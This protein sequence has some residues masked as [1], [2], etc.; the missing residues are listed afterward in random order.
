MIEDGKSGW[1]AP[2]ATTDGLL[3]ALRGAFAPGPAYLAKMGY[4]GSERI[5]SLCNN[6]RITQL[7]LDF[8]REVA[9]NGARQSA[10]LPVN[11]PWSR[12]PLKATARARLARETTG[13]IAVVIAGSGPPL[14]STLASLESQSEGPVALAIVD[15]EKTDGHIPHESIRVS[16]RGASI[17]EKKNAGRAALRDAGARYLG[18]VFLESGD[19]L[20]AAFLSTC[21]QILEARPEVGLISSWSA[22]AE[23]REGAEIRPCPSF[24]YQWLSNEAASFSAVRSEAL[25]EAGPF[26]ASLDSGYENWDLFNSILA[27]GWVGVTIPAVLGES[28]RPSEPVPGLGTNADAAMRRRLLGRFPELLARDPA[29]LVELVLLLEARQGTGDAAG[30]GGPFATA[31]PKLRHRLLSKLMSGRI[32]PR[33]PIGRK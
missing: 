2:S 19:R 23:E 26:D 6:D 9:A 5:R 17:A 27:A 14:E 21:R 10:S 3:T 32:P 18:L 33:F 31:T 7:Q 25:D 13:G 1:I 12:T 29:E 16:L 8:R 4:G 15:D 24:P 11:L 22:R 28:R 30:F 20:F